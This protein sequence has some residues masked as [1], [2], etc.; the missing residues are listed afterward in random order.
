V[1][2]CTNVVLGR[3]SPLKRRSVVWIPT[4]GMYQFAGRMSASE[5][6]D[7]W[8]CRLFCF[9]AFRDVGAVC[10]TL[11]IAGKGDSLHNDRYPSA[12]MMTCNALCNTFV[13]LMFDHVS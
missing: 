10:V 2:S 1:I 8:E 11:F 3:K 13:V 6:F 7:P 9:G 5:E 4:A 12:S